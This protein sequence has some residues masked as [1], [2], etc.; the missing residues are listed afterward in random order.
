[1]G[2]FNIDWAYQFILIF[3]RVFLILSTSFILSEEENSQS[4]NGVSLVD[5]PFLNECFSK[6][7]IIIV[8]V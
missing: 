4:F 7:I 3:L 8:N 5:I 1:M 6:I 2:Y